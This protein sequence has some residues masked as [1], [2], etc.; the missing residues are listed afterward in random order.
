MKSE[1]IIIGAGLSGLLAARLL[2]KQGISVV[3]LEARD[4]IG[5][6][7]DTRKSA[8]DTPIEMGATWFGLKHKNLVSLLHEL[9]IGSFEQY[10]KGT[11]YFESFSMAPPQPVELPPEPPSL[12]IAGGTAQI[13]KALA[14]SISTEALYLNHPVKRI[15][16]EDQLV[17]VET[18]STIFEAD[19]VIAT[20]PP[21]L[22]VD[23]IEFE[24]KLPADLV[25]VA[26]TTHT[27]MQDSIKLALVY[28]EPFWKKKG[29][30]GTV[31]S[32]VGPIT[33]F[34][35]HSDVTNS[36]Y[37]LCGFISGGFGSLPGSIRQAKV[38]QQL[39]RTFG[40]AALDYLEY[41]EVNWANEPFTKNVKGLN[42]FPH[43]NNGHK[44]Y[45]QSWFDH[46]F[47]LAGT[48][49]SSEFGGYMDGA[50]YAA[51]HACKLLLS[52]IA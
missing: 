35:D 42:N 40:K 17:R 19:K 51:R 39:E 10:M 26:R 25:E 52:S 38:N 15:S 24:P 22:L 41:E 32:N 44:V 18:V 8:L 48:E 11:A 34:Y 43:Q 28:K 45:Q 16:F 31:F 33:E 23:A 30:S 14:E 47:F 36:K 7:I 37:A 12:R 9:G 1:V 4:R 29:F 13:I 46:R 49:T 2:K 27:W 20:V 3:V 50:V 5:G 21:A 6:R